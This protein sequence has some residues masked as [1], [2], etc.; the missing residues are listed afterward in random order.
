MVAGFPKFIEARDITTKPYFAFSVENLSISEYIR[1]VVAFEHNKNYRSLERRGFIH[2]EYL[3]P[4]VSDVHLP[5]DDDDMTTDFITHY[6]GVTGRDYGLDGLGESGAYEEDWESKDGGNDE[7]FDLGNRI[8]GH[9]SVTDYLSERDRNFG[10]SYLDAD[11][12][13]I[14]N[15][16]GMLVMPFLDSKLDLNVREVIGSTLNSLLQR[17]YFDL[18]VFDLLNRDNSAAEDPVETYADRI[19]KKVGVFDIYSHYLDV[20]Q[21]HSD[22]YIPLLHLEE[23]YH[24]LLD[25]NLAPVARTIAEVVRRD[26]NYVMVSK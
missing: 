5:G 20:A 14:S 15:S 25:V 11:M 2:K 7:I 1:G 6:L 4:T 10:F 9:R 3:G 26:Y 17:G 18:H 16:M 19:A 21:D 8:L 23:A 13:M 22:H 12:S 24:T